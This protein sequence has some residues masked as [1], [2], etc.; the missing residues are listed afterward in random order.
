MHHNQEGSSG[1]VISP[2]QRLRLTTHNAHNRETSTPQLGFEPTI[3]AGVWPQTY[4]LGCTATG[5]GSNNIT[6]LNISQAL[7][8]SHQI[9]APCWWYG[10]ISNKCAKKS[11]SIAITGKPPLLQE[12]QL[13][14]NHIILISADEGKFQVCCLMILLTAKNDALSAS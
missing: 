7:S 9:W 14:T 3:S 6:T 8:Q 5:I 2:S 11:K 12:S 1:R 4:A 13:Q 10:K